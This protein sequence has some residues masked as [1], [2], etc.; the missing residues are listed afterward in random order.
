[1]TSKRAINKLVNQRL[2]EITPSKDQIDLVHRIMNSH[3]LTN[4]KIEGIFLYSDAN[5]IYIDDVWGTQSSF[6]ITGDTNKFYHDASEVLRLLIFNL[7]MPGEYD[8]SLTKGDKHGDNI[9]ENPA[10]GYDLDKFFVQIKLTTEPDYKIF[11]NIDV[12]VNNVG[13]KK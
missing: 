3:Y 12:S 2:K 6:H 11:E 1:M 9:L 13:D 4:Q 5:Q 7:K 8:F 10:L